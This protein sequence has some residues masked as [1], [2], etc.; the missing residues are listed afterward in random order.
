ME[1]EVL[2][3]VTN[4][5]E[6]HKE[7][8]GEATHGLACPNCGGMVPIPEGQ[9]IVHCPFCDLRS[10]VRGERGLQRYQVARRVDREQ[11]AQALRAF[12]KGNRAIAS[13]TLAQSTLTETFL[14]YIPFWTGRARV[15]SWVFGQKQVGSGEH[16]RYEPRE[17]RIVQEMNWNGVACDVGEFGVARVPIHV[18]V[19][20]PF[21]ADDLH[22]QGMVFEP[23]GSASDA[24][25]CAEDEY[26]KMVQKSAK[27]DRVAQVFIRFVRQ[28]MG[29]VYYPLWVLR[30]L[31][32]GRAFQVV[33][34]GHTGQMLYGKAP[35]STFYRAAVL[36][37]GMLAGSVLA[38][39]ISSLILYVALRASDSDDSGG[40]FMLGIGAFAAGLGLIGL[41]Y[42]KFR[43]GEQFEY[44]LHKADKENVSDLISKVT[45]VEKWLDPLR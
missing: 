9:S 1:T 41:A 23:V 16:K 15:L 26:Q 24:R 29:L 42:R 3:T 28:R 36:V 6:V 43:Y 13:D 37:G 22:N 12:L 31:Y 27:L 7:A 11:A 4:S 20:E 18:Q 35:G 34:D 39:D 19:L 2:S 10:W 33:V 8:E 38:V 30:Y 40:L 5:P 21:N 32:K 45:D 17:V 25:Q 14:A 44:R